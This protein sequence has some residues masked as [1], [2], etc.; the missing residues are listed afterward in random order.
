MERTIRNVNYLSADEIISRNREI[1]LKTGGFRSA[2]G[3]LSNSNSLNYLVKVIIDNDTYSTVQEKAAIY[4]FNIITRHIFV[5]G[6]KRTGMSCSILFLELNN[7][8]FLNSVSDDD[9]VDI[10]LGIANGEKDIYSTINWFKNNVYCL[11]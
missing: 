7:C 6:C 2:A 8:N 1:I 10:A 9:I 11:S 4:A 3:I 5:D